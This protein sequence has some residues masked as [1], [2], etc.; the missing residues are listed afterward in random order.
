MTQHRKSLFV[1]SLVA[2]S[3]ALTACGGTS[4][5]EQTIDTT[6]NAEATKV[7][8]SFT[9]NAILGGK[10]EAEA[11]WYQDY[12][13]PE[14]TK[15]QKAKGID[16]TLTFEPNGVDDEKYKTKLALDLQ[17]KSGADVIGMDGIW[18]GEF[19]EAG[20]IKPLTDVAGA[21]VDSWEGWDQMSE[22]VQQ[23]A[24]FDG[25]RY[26]IPQGADGRVLYYNK[27]LFEKAG[28][29]ADWAPASWD[30][31]LAAARALKAAGVSVPIQLNAGTAMGEA[32]TMQGLLP[33]L[34]GTGTKV[35]EDGKWM[36]NSQGLRDALTLYK[37]IYVDEGLGDP[38]L[39]Q[40]TAGRDKSFSEFA[41]SDVGIL[42]ESDYLWRSVINPDSGTAPMPDRDSVVGYTKIPAQTPGSG[43]DGQDFVS[44]S[45]GAARV[46]NP[47]TEFPQQAWELLAFINSKEAFQNR[48]AS[49]PIITPRADVNQIVLKDNPM[50][51][52]VATEVLPITAYRPGLA[53]YPEVSLAL[54]E[55]TAQVVAGTSVDDAAAAYQTAVEKI[56]GSENVASS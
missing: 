18:V 30:D 21:D 31:I 38:V 6:K 50:L 14:F 19:A 40:E 28:L 7:T 47:N 54:Q 11:Q 34:V 16:V 56:V 33:L 25:K 51:N 26:G 52:F 39:Q 48:V 43:V 22:A 35:W 24:A 45:G 5:P 15:Q 27:T 36:G 17:S 49:S 4:G 9:S 29:P 13:I 41:S 8:L 37:T 1:G 23:A 32:T 46:L 10:N 53:E 44:M 20:Y 3:L 42:I 55:A 12:I 2:L